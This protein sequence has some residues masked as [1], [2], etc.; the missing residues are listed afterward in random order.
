M[1]APPKL[2]LIVPTRNRSGPLRRFLDSV[3]RTASRPGNIEVV[4]VIDHDD[5]ESAVVGHSTLTI[6]HVIVPP[7][8]TMGSLNMEG[9]RASAGQYLML[10]NDDVVARTP[11]WDEQA[12]ACMRRFPDGIA[13]VHVNDILLREHLCT[14]PL[15]PRTFCELA[16]GICPREYVRYRIDDHI[17]DVFNLLAFLGHPRTVYLPDVV[18][19]HLNAVDHPQA[20]RVYQSAPDVLAIDAPRFDALFAVRKEFALRL[21]EY[22][23]GGTNPA[24]AAARRALLDAITDPFALR[25]PGRQQVVRGPWWRRA[26]AKARRP[27]ELWHG[28]AALLARAWGCVR[29]K[30]VAGLAQAVARRVVRLVLA[31]SSLDHVAAAAK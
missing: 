20:G 3:A 31:R 11:R 30:G 5:H 22:I 28:G 18:F 7:G 27:E 12:L 14:F 9:Y 25:V 4:L 16:G 13:L 21:V 2:S 29:R 8:L 1:H 6:K 10:L 19:E 15:L 26:I 17:E 23:E 24:A